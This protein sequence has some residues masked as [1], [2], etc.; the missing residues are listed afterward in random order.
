MT[1]SAFLRR[2][3]PSDTQAL[4]AL[5][6]ASSLH[7][8]SEAQMRAELER[9]APDAVLVLDSRAGILAYGAFRIVLDELHVM[10]LA[11][12]P[13][14]RRRGLGRF[15]LRVALACG[16]RDGASRALLEVRAGNAAARALYRECGF[17]AIGQRKQYYSDPTEDALVLERLGIDRRLNQTGRS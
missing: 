15:L 14:A 12:R 5:E 10:N 11:V 13:E 6:A 4:A 7:P 8:W 9:S 16:G 1:T 2:A 17:V 3:G